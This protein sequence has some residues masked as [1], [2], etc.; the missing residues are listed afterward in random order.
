MSVRRRITRTGAW[1][2]FVCRLPSVANVCSAV[3]RRSSHNR[4]FFRWAAT[5]CCRSP[6]ND[7]LEAKNVALEQQVLRCVRW[8]PPPIVSCPMGRIVFA[9]GPGGQVG[10]VVSDAL[11]LRLAWCF[12]VFERSWLPPSPNRNSSSNSKSMRPWPRQPG[13]GSPL[14][15]PTKPL[16]ACRTKMPSSSQA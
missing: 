14:R 7:A 12:V 13:L 8:A 11:G 15:N 4:C 16:F 2:V 3:A 9:R 10:Q 6:S 5:Y 1:T